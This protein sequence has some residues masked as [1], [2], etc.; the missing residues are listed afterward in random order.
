MLNTILI[1]AVTVLYLFLC[2]SR[3]AH[4]VPMFEQPDESLLTE[5]YQCDAPDG[6]L[7]VCHKGNC[8]GKWR[9]PRAHHC[10]ACGV[11]RLEF[12]H[13]CPWV[14]N[15]ITGSRLKAFIALALLVPLAYIVAVLPVV[16]TLKRHMWHAFEVSRQDPWAQ[17]SWWDWPG[18]W[19]IIAGPPG[20]WIIGTV[21]GYILLN[22]Q[23]STLPVGHGRLL[24]LPY[25]RV[26]LTAALAFIFS[27]FALI[28]AF[29]YLRRVS[30]GLLTFESTRMSARK[31]RYICIPA[32]SPP[33]SIPTTENVYPALPAEILYDLGSQQNWYL[34]WSGSLLPAD[35]PRIF[36]WPKLNL[37]MLQRMKRIRAENVNDSISGSS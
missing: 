17:E 18:S 37:S 1:A 27:V 4:D 26:I 19:I 13:H 20:R 10:S 34:F 33:S 29:F 3:W 16:G 12:D 15:C 28:L 8:N 24:E 11:C 2:S 21:I 9:P 14:G 22:S 5:P 31:P 6:K 7:T 32:S 35:T 36:T 30:Q 25:L 23:R